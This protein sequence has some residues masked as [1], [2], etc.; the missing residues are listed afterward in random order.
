[1][2]LALRRS[3]RILTGLLAALGL[4]V[5]LVTFTPLTYWYSTLLA[6]RWNDPRG[7][8]LIVLGG[9]TLDRNTL[10]TDSYWRCVYA[11][12]VW[13]QGGFR[14]VVVSGEGVSKPMRDLLVSMQV[15]ADA[16]V[17]ETASTSTHESAVNLQR[18]LAA[19]PG[20]KVLLTSDYHMFRARRALAKAG[21]KVRLRPYPD[22][23]KR[24][25]RFTGRWPAF[26]D[27]VV[28]TGKIVYYYFHGWI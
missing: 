22:V 4:L 1:M 6:G 26:L 15:P 10:A 18:L 13:R 5:V 28:E 3:L 19:T 8:V 2:V 21:L 16:I 23:R 27:L 25:Q 17:L 11:S 9:G 12:L 24:Y 14:Q 20:V 7:D